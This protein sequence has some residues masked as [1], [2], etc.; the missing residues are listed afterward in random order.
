VIEYLRAK[1][2]AV[3]GIA[4]YGYAGFRTALRDVIRAMGGSV[5]EGNRWANVCPHPVR[6]VKPAS[7]ECIAA[8]GAA[9]CPPAIIS[10]AAS[11]AGKPRTQGQHAAGIFIVDGSAPTPPLL[12]ND[13]AA[14]DMH[15]V[16]ACGYVKYDLLGLKTLSI[17]SRLRA[18]IEQRPDPLRFC[19][20]VR[21]LI[22]SGKLHGVFQ[23]EASGIR[24]YA[25]AFQPRDIE[26]LSDI[27][28]LYRPGPLDSG[29]AQEV[30]DR[31]NGKAQTDRP[32]LIYQE[33]VMQLARDKAG[34]T[35]AEADLLRKAIGK[36]KPEELA[37][38]ADRLGEDWP[39]IE[40]F[41]AYSFNKAHSMAYAYLTYD[42]AWYKAH[43]PAMFYAACLNVFTDREDVVR[44]LLAARYEMGLKLRPPESI[45]DWETKAVDG[46][47]VLGC[48]LLKGC[49]KRQK[50]PGK[51]LIEGLARVR[52]T[53]Q[54][55]LEVLGITGKP[56]KLMPGYGMVCH[57]SEYT[58][59]R[60]GKNY[61]RCV[62]DTGKQC[63]D[64]IAFDKP[65]LGDLVY[66][67]R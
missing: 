28:A 14:L 29:I 48:N 57:A 8:L 2:S 3:Y 45:E 64:H 61:Y 37:K 40:K 35:M 47:L 5:A 4:A 25:K 50:K 23:I 66:H 32:I 9:G 1:Y 12:R 51:V 43:C 39:T 27:L 17:V 22:W 18:R 11:V 10:A 31:R 24:D 46:G 19:D 53:A 63:I 59:E 62:L 34:Y 41:G 49:K 15:E 26:D 56:P 58:S 65:D 55:Q 54:Q 13:V 16:E 7:E 44:A 36:K 30:L 42:T 21:D 6:G 60:T 67:V 38:H 52:G 20:K 33:Q